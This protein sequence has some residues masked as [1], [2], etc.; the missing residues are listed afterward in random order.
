[1][2][3]CVCFRVLS[4]PVEVPGADAQ[5]QGGLLRRLFGSDAQLESQASVKSP[6][7]ADGL[8][9]ETLTSSPSTNVRTVR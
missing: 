2:S 6:S 1:M 8:Q 3:G 7:Q 9:P 5:E 4:G